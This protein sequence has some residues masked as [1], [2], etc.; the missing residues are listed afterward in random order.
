[1]DGRL[2]RGG[3]D[4]RGAVKGRRW[5]DL[6]TFTDRTFFDSWGFCS[7]GFPSD[8]VVKNPPSM[9]ETQTSGFNP[10]VRKIPWRRAWKPAPVFLPGESQGHRNLRG[11]SP[12]GC[13]ESDTTEAT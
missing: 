4:G 10:W 13:K 3:E 9:Q 2:D 7:W 11:Y 1:M 12:Q 8:S 5:I 6:R